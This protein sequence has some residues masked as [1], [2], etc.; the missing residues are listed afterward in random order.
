MT[1]AAVEWSDCQSI[2]LCFTTVAGWIEVRFWVKTLGGR[3]STVLDRDSDPRT[4]MV[5]VLLSVL[6]A[7]DRR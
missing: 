2:C 3:R 4:A 6:F 7:S 5:R 1:D